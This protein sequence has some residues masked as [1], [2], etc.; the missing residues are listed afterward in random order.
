[1]LQPLLF[2]FFFQVVFGTTAR[3]VFLFLR[4]LKPFCAKDLA[5]HEQKEQKLPMKRTHQLFHSRKANPQR[6]IAIVVH[7]QL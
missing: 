4:K 1:M 3:R 6:M 2:G 5:E 7:L